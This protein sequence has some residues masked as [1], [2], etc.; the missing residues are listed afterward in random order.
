M[1]TETT[2]GSHAIKSAVPA[3]RLQTALD[4]PPDG[5]GRF[6]LYWMTAFRRTGWNFAL[7]R[8]VDWS[9]ALGKP[10]WIVEPLPLGSRWRNDRRHH[11]VLDGMADN[12]GRLDGKPAGYYPFVERQAGQAEALLDALAKIACVVVGDDHPMP[13]HAMPRHTLPARCEAVDSNGLLPLRAATKVFARAVDF[14]RFLQRS[15][16]DHL[17]AAPKADP[18]GRT[19][20]PPPGRLPR[21]ITRKFPAAP[22]HWLSGTRAGLAELPIDHGVAPSAI[23]GG[24][25]AGR[26][27]LRRFLAERLEHYNE[28]RNH[29]DD[30]ATSGLSPYLHF[31]H[32]SVHEVFHQLARREGWS[33]GRLAEKATGSREGWWG[34]RE[35]AEAFLDELITWRELG[36]NF[37][38][39]RDDFDRYES[40]PDWAQETL[41]EHA[42]DPRRHVYRLDELAA[43]QTHDP[44]WNAAQNQLVREG[45]MHNYLRML[46]GKNILQW[47]PAPREALETMIELNDT[48]ALD[49]E[50][51]NS[52]SGIG[53]VLG[54]YDRPWGPERPV[55]GKVRYMTSEN[56][57]R[58]LRLRRYLD[59]WRTQAT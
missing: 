9:R 42:S 13:L 3:V 25:T 4:R 59:Q 11:F 8:A 10:L 20:L 24:E 40:L 31:G 34:M 32:V 16:P 22:G 35:P 7:E 49:G 21:E 19:K 54:R 58:K 44:L 15:L 43:G 47:T 33:P 26:K 12:A 18:L 38:S 23:R 46:W 29:P 6:V 41:A 39:R 53:W 45:R 5:A 17:P 14:R 1:S 51:P 2:S 52:Y 56:T 36:Y 28:L 55:F 37:C 50:D 57:A 27:L 30:D 48:Y